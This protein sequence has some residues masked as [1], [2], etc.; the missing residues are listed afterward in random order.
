MSTDGDDAR[1]D[2][3]HDPGHLLPQEMWDN[4]QRDVKRLQEEDPRYHPDIK[5]RAPLDG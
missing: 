1:P 5:Q 3:T 4:V 2:E